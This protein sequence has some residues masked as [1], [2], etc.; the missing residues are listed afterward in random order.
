MKEI[1]DKKPKHF[2]TECFIGVNKY[3]NE[4]VKKNI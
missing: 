2:P 4:K 3:H 1:A